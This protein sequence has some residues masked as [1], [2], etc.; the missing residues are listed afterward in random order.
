M[1]LHPIV[2]PALSEAK[3]AA[4]ERM[5]NASPDAKI[6]EY[7]F[8]YVDTFLRALDRAGYAVT[9]KTGREAPADHQQL[10]LDARFELRQQLRDRLED[11]PI[12]ED[13]DDDQKLVELVE[14]SDVKALLG[15]PAQEVNEW[16][17][18]RK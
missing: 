5:A 11:L 9:P 6:A 12:T 14:Y 2:G 17:G 7:R 13:V 8:T 4:Q 3:Q 16:D 10:K 1:N 15:D 18:A